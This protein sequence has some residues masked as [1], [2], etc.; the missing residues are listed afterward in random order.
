MKDWTG[1]EEAYRVS[2]ATL[3]AGTVTMMVDAVA[4]GAGPLLDV[5]CGTGELA[6]QALRRGHRVTALDPDPAMVAMTRER[7]GEDSQACLDVAA[8]PD[9]PY[10]N[11]AYGAVCANFVINHVEDPRACVRELARVAAPGARVAMTI[12][13]AAGAGWNPLV[14]G[15]FTD[16]GVVP[17]ASTRLPEHLDFPRTPQ[18]L[19]ALAT[20][21]DLEVL[22]AQEVTWTWS[23]SPEDLWAG[24]AGGVATV[25]QT[26]L[27]QEPQ[28]QR[29]AARRYRERAAEAVAPD[30]M[31][32][33]PSRAVLVLASQS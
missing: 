8:L 27:A 19:A 23:V 26:F 10:P 9:L 24:V 3:C 6:A 2:F 15:A 17:V 20:E 16:A 12:W 25:G 32:H 21:A 13:P 30:G 33:L 14:G 5:G 4:G 22:T 18:G 7:I 31:L 29:A 28:V 11:G 1:V